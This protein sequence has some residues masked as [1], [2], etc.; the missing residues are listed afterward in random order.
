MLKYRPSAIMEYLESP[1]YFVGTVA[2]YASAIA[3][4]FVALANPI[5]AT[6]I[7]GSLVIFFIWRNVRITREHI[8]AM[9]ERA[10][11]QPPKPPQ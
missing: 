11:P 10:T 6:G 9:Y 5:A 7:W 8:V 1:L 3:L 2:A 4:P